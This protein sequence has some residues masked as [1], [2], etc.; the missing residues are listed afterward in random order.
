MFTTDETKVIAYEALKYFFKSILF[1]GLEIE[2][3]MC[4][5]FLNKCLHIRSIRDDLFGDESLIK[6]L[7]I[8]QND[9]ERI[10]NGIKEFL[11]RSQD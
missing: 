6:Y 10:L 9:N 5:S 3:I 11:N 7:K 1:Y 2:K 4:L 8:Y